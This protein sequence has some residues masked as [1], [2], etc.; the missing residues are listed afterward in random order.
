VE[1]WTEEVIL[2]LEIGCGIGRLEKRRNQIEARS[3]P[4]TGIQKGRK[5]RSEMLEET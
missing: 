1:V 4:E 2:T 3:E 5:Q